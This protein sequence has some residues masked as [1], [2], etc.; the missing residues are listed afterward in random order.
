MLAFIGL[1]AQSLVSTEPQLKNAVLE[2]FTGI[3]CGYCPDGHV[4][5]AELLENNPGRAV[6]IAIH[7][8]SFA[9]PN[10]GD[11]D[12]TTP[13]G[14]AL[15]DQAGVTGYPNGTVNRHVFMGGATAMG[16]GDWTPSANIIMQEVS[17]VNVG[18]ESSYEESTRE[19][20]VN[21]ELYYT[22]DAAEASN[23]INVALIQSHIFGPQSSGGAGNNYEHM[24]MLRDMITGQWG[25]EISETTEGSFVERTYTYT[26][27]EEFNDVECIVEDCEVVVFVAETHQEILSGDVVHAIG[28][29]NQFIGNVVVVDEFDIQAG[30]PGN[31]STFNLEAYS[32]LTDGEEFE[33]TLEEVDVPADWDATFTIDGQSYSGTATIAFNNAETKDVTVEVT[34]GA[35]PKVAEYLMTLSSVGVPDAP[36]KQVRFYLVSGV[37]DLIVNGV[38][39]PEAVDFQDVYIDGLELVCTSSSITNADV[40]VKAID[41]DALANVNNIYMNISWT[42]PAL[43]VPQLE[44]TMT[45]MDN[46][47]NLLIAG[48]DIGWDFMSGADGSHPSA[49]ATDF[50]ENYLHADYI[51]DGGNSNN[52][53][54][55]DP[56]DAVYGG[57]AEST[58]VDQFGGNMY[59][60]QLEA[61][62]GGFEVFF[63]NSAMDKCGAVR[64]T[65]AT[66]KVVYFGIGLEMLGSEDAKNQII[67]S[68]KV[69]FDGGALAPVASFEADEQEIY[70]HE[71][72]TFTDLSLNAPT[73]W[74]WEF[75][76]GTP[77]TSDEQ[78]PTIT[79]DE[80]GVF[81]VTLTVSNDAGES[82]EEK[83]A[84]ITVDWGEGID[85]L[86]DQHI[87]VYPNPVTSGILNLQ[88]VINVTNVEV[89]DQVGR[90]VLVTEFNSVE[91]QLNINQ[92]ENGLYIVRLY[93]EAGA[94]NKK[95]EKR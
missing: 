27:P 80:V 1:N 17:P 25:D 82:S 9:T 77:A 67:A 79:Y 60:D 93:T 90:K 40:M 55:A 78:N 75:E 33:I 54:F 28:G 24:H 49:E 23:F 12:Y 81:G 94:I 14:D 48:Q 6:V 29:T 58:V 21:V 65:G 30:S 61:R 34:P 86:E 83:L 56:A 19:L 59:P 15:A 66:Y 84:Y 43:T 62:D 35:T 95:I 44:A 11:P 20:T 73:A 57:T 64:A 68:T 88:S 51:D 31:V 46:G 22:A 45:F 39:G 89:Y 2:E 92:L 42:F 47:G 85:R 69:W 74:S 38:G 10:P 7:Q 16:R 87:A 72:V 70:I 53:Y 37:T 8:G 3:Y 71:T 41:A 36:A 4:I 32:N 91:G 18:I 26:V 76:S 13:W 63:Y 5:A 52:Q 50:Y